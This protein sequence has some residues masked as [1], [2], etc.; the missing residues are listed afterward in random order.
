MSMKTPG[1]FR[2]RDLCYL[3]CHDEFELNGIRGWACVATSVRL[4]WIPSLEKSHQLPRAA[5]IRSG[6]VL[7]EMPSQP[8]TIQVAH[9]AHMDYFGH[10]PGI[11]ARKSLEKE[12]GSVSLLA[13]L[14]R[15]RD[16][17]FVPTT[18]NLKQPQR[19][20]C[21]SCDSKLHYLK[22]GI[23]CKTCG[24]IVCKKCLLLNDRCKNCCYGH[25]ERHQLRSTLPPNF[26]RNT[27]DSDSSY[28]FTQGTMVN[29]PPRV[30][31]TMTLD[32]NLA[33]D[34]ATNTY[35][36][37]VLIEGEFIE[38]VGLNCIYSLRVGS[39][40]NASSRSLNAYDS[41]RFAV[42]EED[43]M[44]I[45]CAECLDEAFKCITAGYQMTYVYRHGEVDSCTGR[46]MDIL[47]CFRIKTMQPDAA[48]IYLKG[49]NIDP[50]REPHVASVWK[51]KQK[52]GW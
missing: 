1:L 51:L 18:L 29:T 33:S 42:R 20:Y 41:T 45:S 21:A 13:N 3:E 37:D 44:K 7:R 48:K 6:Y 25:P 10:M 9:I 50:D 49:T 11:V 15:I 34:S 38:E 16:T 5:I 4:P 12:A 39:D 26:L 43:V 46:W 23:E 2:N 22:P 19:G 52:P 36:S 17:M 14:L 40:A 47:R 30:T 32:K 27:S 8:G 35:E 28:R 31:A 24:D